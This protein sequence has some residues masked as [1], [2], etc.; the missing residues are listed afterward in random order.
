MVDA[1][2]K[3]ANMLLLGQIAKDIL[4]KRQAA[5]D[6]SNPCMTE[7][8][9]RVADLLQ[10]TMKQQFD[11]RLEELKNEGAD[12]KDMDVLELR[13]WAPDIKCAMMQTHDYLMKE[14][15]VFFNIGLSSGLVPIAK[16][17]LFYVSLV[18]GKMRLDDPNKTTGEQD[19][20]EKKKTS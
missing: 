14:Y 1:K 8:E 2:D 13:I 17:K 15:G 20:P 3:L 12:F 10:G 5:F 19:A 9:S 18:V 11:K 16:D 7:T 6:A 4:E